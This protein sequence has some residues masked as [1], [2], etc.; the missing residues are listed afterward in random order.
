MDSLRTY[1]EFN[2]FKNKDNE[3]RKF[4]NEYDDLH[5][6]N[7]MTGIRYSDDF[8]KDLIAKGYLKK[9]VIDLGINI[10]K[11]NEFAGKILYLRLIGDKY[12]K[13]A[14]IRKNK[15]TGK[16]KVLFLIPPMPKLKRRNDFLKFMRNKSSVELTNVNFL[17]D[18][19]KLS[20]DEME[21][22]LNY[23]KKFDDSDYNEII[24]KFKE[25]IYNE[26]FKNI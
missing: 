26:Q 13:I 2:L 18:L 19:K 8:L 11:S 25:L 7:D 22:L 16:Y 20:I 5:L 21:G 3:Y 10:F 9:Y 15:D 17:L 1:E 12:M 24:K 14:D 6:F 23:F 4:M